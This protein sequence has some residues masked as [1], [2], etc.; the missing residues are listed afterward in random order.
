VSFEEILKEIVS[1]SGLSEQKILEKINEKYEEFSG[2]ITKEGAAYIVARDLGI[3]LSALERKRRL[4][5]KNIFPGMKN[6]NVIGRVFKISPITEFSRQNGT[7][8]RVCNVFIGDETGFFRLPLWNDQVRNVEDR[9]VQE[10]DV[11]QITNGVARE[12]IFGDIEISLGKYGNIRVIEDLKEMPSKEELINKFFSLPTKITLIKDVTEGNSRILGTIVHIFKGKFLFDICPICGT[13]IV[14]KKCSTDGEVEPNKALVISGII[15]DGTGT[16]R[17]ALFRDLA[18]KFI[19][20]KTDEI[21]KMDENERHEFI[22]NK[23]LGKDIELLGRVRKSNIS[24]RLE[25]IVSDVKDLNIIE[26]SKKLAREIESI[27][28]E[29]NA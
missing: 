11:V 3:D 9:L 19:G 16:L 28:G 17:F 14:N 1:K 29:E 2:L 24:K 27:I 22:K 18:E 21:E 20:A 23:V 10:G 26:E 7:I 8:G 12:N 4:Q 5:I 13:K 25:M 15:D 6:I